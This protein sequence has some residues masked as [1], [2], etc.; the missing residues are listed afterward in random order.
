MR[1]LRTSMRA[2]LLAAGLLA[3]PGAVW[4]SSHREAPSISE[5][6]VADNTDLYAF[7]DPID[8][9]KVTII[10]TW[11][12]FETPAGGPVFYK[13]GD[14]VRYDLDV[15]N[16]GDGVEDIVYQFTF[17]TQVG[18]P[19]SSQYATG[20]ITAPADADLNVQQTFRVFK[21]QKKLRKGS[22]VLG[23]GLAT[24]P[25]NVGP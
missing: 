23:E 6:P 24:P 12:P 11:I 9:S 21:Q 1:T 22:F 18:N 20:Q 3:T 16:D 8:A 10:A 25:V 13:F 17:T 5:D 2:V 19:A 7:V 4:A 14:E 15:D